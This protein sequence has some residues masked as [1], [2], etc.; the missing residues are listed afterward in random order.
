[1]DNQPNYYDV[2]CG[3]NGYKLMRNGEVIHTR[4]RQFRKAVWKTYAGAEKAAKA[5]NQKLLDAQ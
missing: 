1:M 4:M 3:D 5:L 2:Y